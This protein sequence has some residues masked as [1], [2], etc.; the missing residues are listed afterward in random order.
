[1]NKPTLRLD[2]GAQERAAR[3]FAR[4][5]PTLTLR[6]FLRTYPARFETPPTA[7]QLALPVSAFTF[8]PAPISGG[9]LLGGEGD[10][11][12]GA[13]LAALWAAEQA[14]TLAPDAA[15]AAAPVSATPAASQ[16]AVRNRQGGLCRDEPAAYPETLSDDEAVRMAYHHELK[17]VGDFL[18]HGLSVLVV[19]DKILTEFVYEYVCG[20]AGRE[21]VRDSD[22]PAP[23]QQP[24]LGAR[25]DQALQGPPNPLAGLEKLLRAL[26]PNQT[27]VLRSLDLLDKPEL[28]ELLYQRTGDGRKPQL[29]AFL[30]PSLEVKKV[31][32]DRFAAHIQ[33]MGLPRHIS[34]DGAQLEYAVSRLLTRDE[35][36][37]FCDYSAEGLFKHVAG[38]N[39]VQ[40]RNAMQYVAATVQPGCEAT[41]I[42]RVIRQFKTSSN[43]AIEIPDTTF[44]DIGGYEQV[45]QQLQRAVALIGGPIAGLDEKQRK[46]LIPR[47]FIFH[48]PPGTG[49]TLFA[50]AIANEMNATIQMVSGPEIMDKYVGQSETNLRRIFATARRNAP[51]VIFFDEFDSI[52]SQRSTYSDGGARANNAVVAQFL[53]ELDGF[54]EGQAVLVIGT[55]N[56]I[57]IIDE[58]LLRPSR[59]R[60][61]EIAL[62]DYIAR[63]RVAEIHARSFGVDALLKDLCALALDHLPAW[64]A[65][66]G[67]TI[68]P[69]FLAALYTQHEPY[70]I[71]CE[72]ETTR[73]DFLRDLTAFFAFIHAAREKSAGAAQT[74]LLE[75]LTT[76]LVEMGREYG[77]PLDGEALPDLSAEE[78]RAWLQPM[79]SDI[80]DLFALLE[81]ERKK[82][83]GL[84]RE[85][86]VSAIMVLVGEYTED[87]NIEVIRA[88]F[89][90]AGLEHHMEGQLVTPRYLGQKIGLIRKRRDEREAMHLSPDRGRR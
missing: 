38:L 54:R 3:D 31:L 15:Q 65:A 57:D 40:F 79:Q 53:T 18:Q 61:V 77:L 49:K 86:F 26:K 75:Q 22:A 52:A 20:L 34:L 68:P 16:P 46:Q 35:R 42:Y 87:F 58:A 70:R 30:D 39:A 5:N 78:A 8:E 76:R 90:E 85:T 88:F 29:L 56:R 59:L 47:G 81:Q 41:H 12:L 10:A 82:Q 67:Q 63:Q 17:A 6:E 19:C 7:A 32:T 60:P 55:T 73:A 48:G 50:K 44:A 84:T 71:R 4:D 62:P 24:G 36:A 13:E 21:V 83:G 64:E 69:A 74:G 37:R 43:E 28:T 14:G 89:E 72:I 2:L 25:L 45:K 51:S 9:V 80:R 1:M 66:G 33:L 11:S 23:A 27:L